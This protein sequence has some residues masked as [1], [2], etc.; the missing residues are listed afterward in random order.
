[1]CKIFYSKALLNILT[2]VYLLAVA[3]FVAA[4]TDSPIILAKN[5]STDKN[6]ASGWMTSRK[7]IIFSLSGELEMEYVDAQ[8]N[9]DANNVPSGHFQTDK[10]TVIP[11]ARIDENISFGSLLLFKATTAR[12][13]EVY[14]KV[15]DLPFKSQIKIGMDDRITNEWPKRLT[16]AFPLIDSAFARDDEMGIT[17]SRSR[18]K[19]YFWSFTLTNGYALGQLGPSEDKSYKFIHD[20]RQTADENANKTVGLGLG[21]NIFSSKRKNIGVMVYSYSGQLSQGDVTYLQAITG[22][23]V[24]NNNT[25]NR[26]GLALNSKAGNWIVGA[27]NIIAKDGDLNRDGWFVQSA[28]T[29]KLAP[30]PYIQTVTPFIRYGEL[31][32]DISDDPADSL[33]WD[34][35]MTTLAVL[36]G[37]RKNFKIKVE[38]YL[39]GEHTGAD[40][41]D[42]DE[43]VMQFEAKF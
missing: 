30:N 31:N 4:N 34:R 42:N 7:Q 29:I 21:W 9:E 25:N 1:M 36:L 35:S 41:V 11:M 37:I 39:N 43:F 33:T 18:T 13:D 28:Y 12:V 15:T 27:K 20:D 16:E 26:H 14:L 17:W 6:S 40:E 3:D 8:S 32:V 38:Y 19:D 5:D 22:Y 24:S 23:G 10:F 2:V